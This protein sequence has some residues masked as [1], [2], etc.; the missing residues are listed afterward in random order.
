MDHWTKSRQSL[1]KTRAGFAIDLRQYVW[2]TNRSMTVGNPNA[3]VGW[4]KLLKKNWTGAPHALL[5]LR[6]LL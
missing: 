6:N 2:R 1:L 4:R 5:A 3:R